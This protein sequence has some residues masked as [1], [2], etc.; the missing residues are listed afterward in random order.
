MKYGEQIT[1]EKVKYRLA[2]VRH[3][4]DV[5]QKIKAGTEN[6]LAALGRNP[7]GI[8]TKVAN[9][10]REKLSMAQTKISV[11]SQAERRYAGLYVE[12]LPGAADEE[13]SLLGMFI[14]QTH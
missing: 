5:E 2:E 14:N 4:L 7:A 12:P 11:L 6:L 10:L 9:E 13:D 3:R 1:S 8:D